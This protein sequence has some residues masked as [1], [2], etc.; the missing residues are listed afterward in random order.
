MTFLRS[1]WGRASALTRY[2]T[3]RSKTSAAGSPA[4]N[5][6]RRDNDPESRGALEQ[7]DSGLA[8][9]VVARVALVR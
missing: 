5:R 3:G 4:L 2:P 1:T 6:Q 9:T 7:V 8:K